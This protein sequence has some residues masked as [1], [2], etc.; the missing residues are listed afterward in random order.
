MRCG[1]RLLLHFLTSLVAIL[2]NHTTYAQ[3]GGK[4]VKVL[5]LNGDGA[6]RGNTL[7]EYGKPIAVRDDYTLCLR[8]NIIVF[9]LLTAV[10]YIVDQK[11]YD[12]MPISL[13]VYFEKIRPKFGGY[14]KFYPLPTNLATNKWYFY[15]QTRNSS[16]GE[17]RV[18]LDGELLVQEMIPF[19]V[20]N[21]VRDTIM[22]QDEYMPPYSMSGQLSQVNMWRRVLSHEEILSLT[23]CEVDLEGDIISWSGPWKVYNAEEKYVPLTDL[24]RSV[25]R[26]RMTVP[27]PLLRYHDAV[28][29]CRGLRGYIDVPTTMAEV[30]DNKAYFEDM[31]E[32]ERWVAPEHLAGN[33]TTPAPA[34]ETSV[35]KECER[36]WGGAD[37]EAVEGVWNNPFTGVNLVPASVLS[38]CPALL[39][40][41]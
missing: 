15:C 2:L 27:L 31:V 35:F 39:H 10:I 16:G 7:A 22:G 9:R 1:S 3:K 21:A 38:Q 32:G 13:D 25:N 24:C 5:T 29:L 28:K 30:Y 4:E 23:R 14:G 11:D 6:Q 19:D 18:Y 40:S 17:G 33:V 36:V 12:E 20:D 26:G 8:F 41:Y 37:D 34:Q